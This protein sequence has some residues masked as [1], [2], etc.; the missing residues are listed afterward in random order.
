M[1]HG[2][3]FAMTPGVLLMPLS[4]VD[5]WD[6]QDLVSSHSDLFYLHHIMIVLVLQVLFCKQDLKLYQQL[7]LDR[8]LDL[9]S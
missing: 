3:P 2:E 9:F 6:S 7:S 4:H 8:E 5:R 1:R